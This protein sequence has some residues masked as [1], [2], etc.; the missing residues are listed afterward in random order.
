MVAVLLDED[1]LA[2]VRDEILVVLLNMFAVAIGKAF[3]VVLRMLTLVLALVLDE[4]DLVL[5]E[6]D[7]VVVLDIALEDV[8]EENQMLADVLHQTVVVMP[9]RLALDEAFVVALDEAF[10]VAPDKALLV[11]LD[12]AFVVA[13]DETFVVAPD[14]T[15]PVASLAPEPG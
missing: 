1:T 10:V 3:K 6:D 11:T 13:L 14:E 4:E 5:A 7:L 12:E 2:V 8:P 9:A 15:L